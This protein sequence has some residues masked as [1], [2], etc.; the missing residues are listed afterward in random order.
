MGHGTIVDIRQENRRAEGLTG[1][2][3]SLGT[4]LGLIGL[5]ATVLIAW[6]TSEWK[7]SLKAYLLSFSFY[8]SLSLGGLFFVLKQHLTR[9]AWSVLVR[10]IA[11][12]VAHYTLPLLAVFSLPILLGVGQLYPWVTP[13]GYDQELIEKKTLYLNVPFFV[14]RIVAY[15]AI[16]IF[17]ARYYYCS[18]VKQDGSGDVD[19]TRSM[20]RWSPLSLLF[21]A[22]TITLA[23][24]D[25][26][27]SLKPIWYSTIF[28]VYYFAGAYLG[29]VAFM[30]LICVWLQSN[31][32]LSKAISPEHYHDMGKW[33]FAFTVF[34]AY[35][36][37]SQYMLIWYANM[38]EATGWYHQRQQGAWKNIGLLLVFGHFFLPFLAII[39]RVP[40]RIPKLLSVAAIWMLLMHWVDLYYVAVPDGTDNVMPLLVHG[41]T[42]VGIGGFFVAAVARGLAKHSLIPERDPRLPESLAFE[43]I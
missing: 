5:I 11:E 42:F 6:A 21:Y 29:F 35:I 33:L 13:A 31:G 4:G 9:A 27:M 43:N 2:I 14:I 20:Q 40:K 8:L 36:A 26:L 32:R 37:F 39:S 23:S 18:S 3:T 7:A 41:T 1:T 38:P 34:W 15:F 17:I 19:L 16:W 25:L 10:R 28:G 12:V 30:I 22:F 24:F